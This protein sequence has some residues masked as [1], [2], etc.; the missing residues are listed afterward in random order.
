VSSLT[1]SRHALSSCVAAALLAGCGG[2]QPPI[3]NPNEYDV[4]RGGCARSEQDFASPS[5]TMV[6]ALRL[7]ECTGAPVVPPSR[8]Y[9]IFVHKLNEIDANNKDTLV[10]GYR[11]WSDA[12][13][14]RTEP[15]V[16]WLRDSLL[17]VHMGSPSLTTTK[18]FKVNG[19]DVIYAS[20]GIKIGA[21]LGAKCPG[22]ADWCDQ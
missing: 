19:I 2:S 7:V 8:D 12:A 16:T 20:G 17:Q 14:W 13:G 1:L 10:L 3:G 11:E 15:K 21:G 4:A 5:G 22:S 18:R 9:F 6:A